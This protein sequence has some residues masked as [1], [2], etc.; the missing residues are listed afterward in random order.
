MSVR[1]AVMSFILRRTLKKQFAA[2]D[3]VVAFRARMKAASNMSG[4]V[5][6]SVSV[7]PINVQGV[8]CEWITNAGTDQNR[9]LMYLHGGG[10]VFGGLDSHREIA[11]RL[12]QASGM[13]VLLVDYRLAPEHV[14]PAA[15]EDAT[16]C[17]RWLLSEGFE[18]ARIAIGGDSAGGG[19]TV[20]TLVNLKNLGLPQP[21]GAIL[22]SPWTDLS[23]SGD[24]IETNE[25]K[26]AML[27]R[28]ALL[29]CAQYYLGE[30]ERRAPLA[31]PLFADL[32]GLPP[33]LIHVGSTEMLCSDAQRLAEKW[34]SAGGEASIEIW[35][36]M[37][38]VFQVLAARIPEG[39]Q[40]IVKLGE[41]LTNRTTRT[42]SS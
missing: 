7:V 28:A 22:L 33:V 14:F 3:D 38:H 32:S 31:S 21:S 42:E 29:K 2:I 19:L 6:D 36:K 17:Y 11:W 39:A 23:L 37:P 35:P 41:F 8:S 30:R 20:A 34:E 9:V 13:R 5:P 40:A 25:A 12:A 4:V 18:P 24:S 26:D 27:S 10:Y 15:L 1:A 16:A